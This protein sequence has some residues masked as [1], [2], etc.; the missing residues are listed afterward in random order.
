MKKQ[1]FILAATL[2]VTWWV[3]GCGSGTSEGR[4][5]GTVQSAD[6]GSE[7]VFASSSFVEREFWLAL[8]EEPGWHLNA[9]RDEFLA[10]QNRRAAEELEKVAAI[11]NFE[12]RHCHS[13]SERGLL[14]ASVSELREVARE[15]QY[16]EVPRGGGPSIEELDRVS[17]LAFRTIAVH[18]VTLGRD[19]LVAGDARM[20]GR[21]IR[22]TT[23]ALEKGF[24]QG[25]IPLG[26]ALMEDLK[27]ARD[28]A[29]RLEMEGEGSREEGIATMDGLAAAVTGLGNV[30][31]ARRK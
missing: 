19:A 13:I 18:Q 24:E 5:A 25:G 4:A 23:K 12:T 7:E 8:A 20:A 15:L 6:E 17:A 30:L 26:N 9:A 28:V 11:L 10:G 22:E 2:G 14:H 3:M 31:T 21:Y 16:R 27:Q 1:I 29:S